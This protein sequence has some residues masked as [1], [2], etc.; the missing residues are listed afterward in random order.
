MTD[1]LNF[2]YLITEGIELMHISKKKSIWTLIVFAV[3]F[4]LVN[5]VFSADNTNT[6]KNKTEKPD[7]TFVA[8][9]NGVEISQID[10]ERK[11]N[12]IKERYASMGVPLDET[13]LNEFRDNILQSLI[14]QEVLYQES[15]SQGI[16]IDPEEVKG[17]LEN[18][19]KQFETE[20]AFQKQLADM[21]YTEDAIL[22]QIKESK[23]IQKFIEDTVMP[24]ITVSDEEAKAYFDAHPDEFKV[25]ERVSASHILIKVDPKAS[26]ATKAEA[27]KKIEV[28]KSK[29]DNG[30]DFA[31]LA[32]KD[33]D[34]PSSAKGGDLGFFGRGQMVKPFEEAAFALNPGEVS[35]VVETQFGYHIIKVQEKQIATTLA[36]DD[37]K[38]KLIANLKEDKFKEMF[39]AYIESLKVKYK[40]VIPGDK[41]SVPEEK[42][43]KE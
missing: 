5:P 35:S 20:A 16:Q 31:E 40:I 41:S 12:L 22:S 17:E 7:D 13:K 28:I 6:P 23:T 21:D 42:P 25:P 3:S 27:M 19:K 33:S 32:I 9:V 14:E 38:E 37:I 1:L 10:L 4:C 2:L 30:E 43:V 29:L 36:Y 39:P 26:E 11:F 18:F 24:T 8:Q 15:V 34:C